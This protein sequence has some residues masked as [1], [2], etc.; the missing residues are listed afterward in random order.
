MLVLDAGN[1]LFQSFGA[2][3]AKREKDRAAFIMATMGKLKTR[4]MA[5]G[6]R[7]LAAGQGFLAEHAKKAGVTL[8][9]ANLAIAGKPAFAGSTTL[10]VDGHKVCLI[11]LTT[12]GPVPGLQNAVA[13]P[14]VAAA[15]E[16]L[17]KLP[18]G[19][20]VKLVLAAIPY[21][22]ALQ[23]G[24]ELKGAV[25][26]ILQSSE[27][28]PPIVQPVNHNH[29]VIGGERGRQLQQL[30]LKLDG[31]GDF[32]NLDEVARTKELLA[33]VEGNLR[34]LEARRKAAESDWARSQLDATIAEMTARR[35]ELKRA[36]SKGA[37][38]GARA[39]T[40][41]AVSLD[42]SLGDDPELLKQLLVF[43]PTGAAAQH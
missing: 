41:R 16:E 17:K 26:F 23:L 13:A 27:L 32:E 9:S 21:A 8:L 18:Q 24:G 28:K 4:A 25:D 33:H 20:A 22:D 31:A 42:A 37:T 38:Q 35:D 12:P 1:A 5:V 15:R 3:P 36:A 10:E 39:F 14:T 34:Q 29:L 30:T 43:E 6:H 2:P 19:C 40:A 11:G 7:D